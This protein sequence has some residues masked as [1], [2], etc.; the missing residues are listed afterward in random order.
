[1]TYAEKIARVTE[2]LRRVFNDPTILR[3]ELVPAMARN[4]A[5]EYQRI[6]REERNEDRGR[7]DDSQGRTR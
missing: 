7:E 2:V 1:M 4:V 3:H 5:R 6:E